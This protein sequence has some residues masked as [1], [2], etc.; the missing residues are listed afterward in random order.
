MPYVQ[1]AFV[2]GVSHVA[3]VFNSPNVYANFVNIALWNDPQG[4]EAAVLNSIN[5]PDYEFEKVNQ[6]FTEGAGDPTSEPTVI[7]T[8]Q[9][10][11]EQGIIKKEDIIKGNNVIPSQ[12][13]TSVSASTGTINT[14]TTITI[15]PD[16]D[17]ILLYDSPN[18]GIKYYVKTVTKQ[19]GVIFPYDVATVAPKNG[20]KVEEVVKNLQLMV[21]NCFDPIKKQFPDAFMTCSF[22]ADIGFAVSPHKSGSACDIQFSKATKADYYQRALWIKD[23]VKFDQFLLEYKTTGSG[24]PWLHLGINS[25]GTWRQ[26]VC[27]FMND[28]N[29]KGP[30]VQG[31]FDLSNA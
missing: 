10:L 19:P 29:C 22:R 23:N 28:R 15:S 3:D 13:N 16:V 31:L 30:G 12:T 7:A 11:I 8:Q 18:T 2:H 25:K 4:P 17:N 27:T 1:G 24:K 5:S 20:F 6:E 21:I 9:K 14:G 26:Q